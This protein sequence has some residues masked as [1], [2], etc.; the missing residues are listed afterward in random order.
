VSVPGVLVLVC[1]L[2]ALASEWT[3][4]IPQAHFAQG[5]GFQ[6]LFCWFA[7]I[8]ALTAVVVQDRRGTLAFLLFGEVAL[9]VWFGWAFWVVTSPPFA[10]LSW[11]FVGI[12]V[13]GP[14]WYTAALGILVAAAVVVARPLTNREASSGLDVW[15]LAA[16]PGYGLIRLDRWG[17]GLIWTILF[18]SAVLLASYSS[19]DMSLFEQFRTYASLPPAP[20]NRLPTWILLAAALVLWALSVVDTSRIARAGAVRALA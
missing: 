9:L 10:R 8:S 12:D 15:L 4:G 17:R 20:V 19:P 14:G 6:N 18:A 7:V 1:A 13:V 3:I 11:P 5:F 2:A 16:I